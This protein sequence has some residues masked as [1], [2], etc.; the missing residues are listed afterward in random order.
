[1]KDAFHTDTGEWKQQVLR[2][3]REA[4]LQGAEGLAS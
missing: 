3:A 2:Q 1:M 4:L